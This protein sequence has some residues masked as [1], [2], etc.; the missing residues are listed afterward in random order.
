MSPADQAVRFIENL[1]LVG[2]YHGRSFRLRP[3][4]SDVVRKLFGTRLPDGRKQYR[5]VFVALPRKQ[6]KTT[7][8]AGIAGNL[9]CGEGVGKRGQQIYSASG[10]RAQAALIFKTLA[11]MIR[12]DK[13]LDRMCRI[14]DGYKRVVFEPLG[15]SY[16]ALSSEAG[17]KHGLSP[18]AVLF[19]ELHVLPN[20][21]L[22]DAL[23]TGFGARMEPLTIYITT[24]GW[25][26]AS[27]CW[28]LWD[29][30]RKVR[31]GVV[32][33]PTFLPILY[34]APPEADWTDERVWH[35]A[36][37]AL[38]DFCSLEFIR[39][40]CRRAKEMPA[41]ENTF[42][43]LYL[44][45]W[46]EQATRWLQAERWKDCGGLG[47]SDLDGRECYAGLDLGVTGDM[48][49]LAL[50]FPDEDNGIDLA[51]RFWVPRDGRWRREQRNAE[52]YPLWAKQG[53][54]TFT[55]GETTDFDRVESD[56]LALNDR[57]P[58]RL[59]L[60]DRAYA[61]HLLSRLFNAHHLPVRGLAQGPITLNEPMVRLEAMILGGR[62]RHT[63][64]PVLAW[65]VAN[66]VMRKNA[67]GLMYLDKSEA[68]RRIDGLAAT[69][70]ALKGWIDGEGEAPSPYTESRGP[71][72]ASV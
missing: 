62:V 21:E 45:Q 4:Q 17:L 63:D 69:L 50:A 35:A 19:D 46:T 59:L 52:L 2:D 26:R 38:G 5:R 10:D 8:I 67:T 24:A 66:A 37:P 56:I 36:M 70:D 42:R 72:W 1:T 12:A 51:C 28:E 54:L 57:W 47:E 15:N 55:D 3:W 60:G 22:H 33:D 58:F 34:E 7:L 41:Y 49:A 25:D 39:D 14:Y 32:D 64:S 71:I 61:T 23:V 11:S 13:K 6:A 43:Q 29:Y 65:N 18:S 44:N 27:L 16:E 30:A 53:F 20:R 40:E 9:L 48:S 68:T 31:D